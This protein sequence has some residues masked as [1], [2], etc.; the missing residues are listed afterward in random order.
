M[1]KVGFVIVGFQFGCCFASLAFQ[2]GAK[3]WDLAQLSWM[4]AL[5]IMIL[6]ICLAKP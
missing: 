3:P 6:G 2:A 1:K 5:G 4:A